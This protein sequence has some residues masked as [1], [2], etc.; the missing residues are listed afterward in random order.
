MSTELRKQMTDDMILK[1]LSLATQRLYLMQV[2]NL[3]KY[4]NSSPD[5]LSREEIRKY[6]LYLICKKKVSASMISTALSAIK[7]I[8]THTLKKE[9]DYLDIS[10]PRKRKNAPIVLNKNEIKKI[11]ATIKNLKHKA[12]ITTIYSAGL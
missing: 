1:G 6:F 10:Y 9:W 3:A 5:K 12:I 7:F 2:N 4:Y 8:Y 11:L